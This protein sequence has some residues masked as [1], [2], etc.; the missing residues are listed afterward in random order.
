MI[1][2]R[3]A[4]LLTTVFAACLSGVSAQEGPISISILKVEVQGDSSY[5]LFSVDNRLDQ[6][7]D[8]LRVSCVWFDKGQPV[9]EEGTTI[10]NVVPLGKTIKREIQS[11]GGPSDKIECRV[12]D[13]D[14]PMH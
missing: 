14:P 8:S 13:S 12:M 5:L 9:H 2:F 11:Y 3:Q 6:R 4:L 1:W 7:F 10:Q